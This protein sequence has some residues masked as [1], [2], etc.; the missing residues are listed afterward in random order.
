[1]DLHGFTMVIFIPC[2]LLRLCRSTCI[3]PTI[4]R[5]PKDGLNGTFLSDAK[6]RSRRRPGDVGV[7]VVVV[8]VVVVW[9][10]DLKKR[11]YGKTV[12]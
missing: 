4:A 2:S 10:M 6:L 1:M 7:V 8:V 9:E 12:N 3:V 11:S 5:S